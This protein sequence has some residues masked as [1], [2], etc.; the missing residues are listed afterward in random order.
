[1]RRKSE[2]PIGPPRPGAADFAE[3]FERLSAD[4]R[5]ALK[6]PRTRGKVLVAASGGVDSAAACLLLAAAGYEVVLV[7]LRLYGADGFEVPSSAALER[8]QRLGDLLEAPVHV[9]DARDVFSKQV[10]EPFVRSY[11]A[12]ETPNPCIWCNPQVKLAT[13][14]ALA[15][16]FEADFFATGHCAR[17]LEDASGP[18]LL[19]ARD[20]SKDQSYMLYRLSLARLQRLVLPLGEFE[21][22]RVKALVETFGLGADLAESM[23]VCFLQ[24]KSY[25]RL[26]ARFTPPQKGDIRYIDNRKLG[27]HQGFWRFTPGQRK[28][29]GVSWPAPLYV[30]RLEPSTNTVF[31]AER[32]YAAR[33]EL[34]A[35]QAN[36]LVQPGSESFTAK[37]AIRYRAR[38]VPAT[39]RPLKNGRFYAR[40]KEAVFG[41]AP[42]QSAV[43]YRG[44]RVLGGGFLCAL[45]EV[46][47]VQSAYGGSH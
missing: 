38:L 43:L 33:D 6:L 41:L 8:L 20:R 11:L 23:D 46:D 44:D 10:I 35:C 25:V 29:L 47:E 45:D 34:L 12:G 37:V 28:G 3:A 13:L 16:D 26:L 36:W 1:M 30:V 42:G 39:C 14:E 9:E 24:G 2:K 40:L 21:K 7:M 31:V 18:Q 32:E 17:V 15:D 4:G 27:E 5:S 19:R 22:R